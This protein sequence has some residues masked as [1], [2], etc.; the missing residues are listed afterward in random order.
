MGAWE[1]TAH[2]LARLCGLNVP[3]SRLESFSKLGSTFLT[4]RFDR[5]GS[6]RKHFS[7]AMTMLGKI[8]GASAEDG[9]GY[10]DIVS[11][12]KANGAAPKEDIEELWKRI[13]F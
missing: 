10:L 7:S 3:E 2:D 8:D 9:S 11:F 1:K 12:L 13:V 6:Q 4:K 5:E